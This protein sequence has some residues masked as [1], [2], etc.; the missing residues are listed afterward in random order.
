[1]KELSASSEG[2]QI[3]QRASDGWWNLLGATNTRTKSS[4]NLSSRRAVASADESASQNNDEFE[5]RLMLRALFSF[6]Y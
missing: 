4:E 1:M 2:L 6:T 5:V 3:L